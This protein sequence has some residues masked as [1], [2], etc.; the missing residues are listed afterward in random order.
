MWHAD[1]D[2][3]WWMVWGGLMMILFWGTIIALAV[4]AVRSLTQPQKSDAK[5]EAAGAAARTPLDIVGERYAS[6]E[7]RREEFEQIRRDLRES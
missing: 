2:M 6:G 1:G 7:I 5:S 4:W 3:G